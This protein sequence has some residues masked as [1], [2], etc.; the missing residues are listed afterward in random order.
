MNNQQNGAQL[1]AAERQRQVSVEGWTP[2]HDDD[3]DDSELT[4]AAT[5]YIQ[6]SWSPHLKHARPPKLWPWSGE[7]WKPTHDAVRD[8]VKA[9]ALIAA[10]SI[11]NANQKG[12][13]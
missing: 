3:R 9:G 7:W 1:I 10:A 2:Q 6:S 4:M 8:L 5:C 12:V 13:L 11:Y